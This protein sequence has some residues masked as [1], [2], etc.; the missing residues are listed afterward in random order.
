MS[1]SAKDKAAHWVR[2]EIRALKA[3]AVP[4]ATGLIKLDAMENPYAFPDDMRRDWLHVL[5]QVDL[6]R[7]PDPA[8]RRL[9]DCLRASLDIPP[10]MSILL[11]NGSD[12]LIQLIAMALAQPRRVVLA[13]VPTFVMYDMIAT[14]T[15]M[16]FV[17][18]PLTPDFDLDLPA[19]LAAIAE[20]RPALIF[21]AYPNNPT[22]NLFDADAMRQILAASDALVVVDE[23]YHA[24]AGVSFMQ[25]LGQHDNLVVMRTLSKQGLAG[26]RLGVL[27]GDAAWL[28]EFDKLRLPYNI[29]SLTQASAEFAL[30]RAAVLQAQAQQLCGERQRVYQAL[31]ALPGVQ[32]WPSRANFILLRLVSGDATRVHQG[33]RER[34]VLIKNLDHAGAA[35]K[36]C[37]RVTIG[38]PDENAAMLAAL[39]R[40]MG[41]GA[42]Q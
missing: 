17:G 19:M 26:L 7:Y 36:G 37:L 22:G 11:G 42:A 13:P 30:S 39:T 10:A 14:F 38:T 2:P 4:D 18:V 16:R 29:N 35:L 5:Q 25:Q 24:F 6:N 41:Q 27:A 33:M 8:A 28:D 3:Y 31:A 1:T 40:S 32:V 15:G 9:K 21:L 20:H 23:A 34:G 12:E